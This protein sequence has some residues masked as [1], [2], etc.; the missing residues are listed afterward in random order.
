M[1]VP[2]YPPVYVEITRDGYG[3]DIVIR[4]SEHNPLLKMWDASPASEKLAYTIVYA[5]NAHVER[6]KTKEKM[7][8]SV[9]VIGPNGGM[10]PEAL[11]KKRKPRCKICQ[12]R[13]AVADGRCSHR[14][15][16]PF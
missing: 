14:D 12:S 16:V 1:K 11:I 8:S 5:L 2:L 7:V 15:C 6:T 9:F 3:D 13:V 4:D 10:V